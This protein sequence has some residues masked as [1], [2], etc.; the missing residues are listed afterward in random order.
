MYENLNNYSLFGGGQH[1]SF[2][3]DN[4]RANDEKNVRADAAD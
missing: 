2:V 1:M 4:G 3:N